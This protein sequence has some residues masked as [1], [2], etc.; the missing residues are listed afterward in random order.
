MSK[1]IIVSSIVLIA[2]G[3]VLIPSGMLVNTSINEMVE[4][5]VDEGL[6]GIEEEALP[7]VESMIAEL[8]I[9]RALRDIRKKGLSELETIVN[10]TFF[11]FLI[12]MT[13]HTEPVLGVV[14]LTMLFDKWIHWVL[15]IPV[16]YSSSLNGMG[17]PPIKGISEYYQ[18]NLWYG[19][20][21]FRIIE[22]T[23]TLPGLVGNN[24]MGT[25]VLEFLEL[26]EKATGNSTLEQEL[27]TGYNAT[28]NQ[29]VKLADYYNDYFVPIAIPMIV[30]NMSVVMPEYTGMDTKDITKMYFY[31]QWANCTVYEDGY[32]FSEIL[33]EIDD[34]LYGFEAGRLEPSN[35]SRFSINALWDD[36]NEKS[37]T[38]DSGINYWIAA[39]ENITIKEELR[40]EFSLE[41][42]QINMILNWLWN[43]SFKWDIV[44]VLITLPPPDGE[45][46]P[47]SEYAKVIFLEV[48]AN[49]TADG[50]SLYPYGFPLE[51]K[52]TTVYG[53]EVGYQNQHMSVI[54]SNISLESARYL[55]NVS[56]EFSLVNK[57]GLE[58]WFYAVENPDSATNFGLKMAN[59]LEDDEIAMILSWLPKFRNNVMPYLAQEEMNLIMDSTSLGNTIQLSMSLTGGVLIS[60]AVVGITRSII[61]KKK[62]RQ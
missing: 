13:L 28:W 53:F 19:A 23:E 30:A 62:L 21:K 59:Q 31:D 18:Q 57:K 44:P 33:D 27:V 43:E 39:A 55:W 54:P 17:Y 12:N 46:M 60:L 22:G 52:T 15:I 47:L 40:I 7:L 5:S 45:G 36:N 61:L 37:L 14:P 25:G 35:I 48:W 29:L 6:L 50:K 26:C 4:S 20:A 56:N 24:T 16:T 8:G 1:K 42:Y 9:P 38:N 51:L 11:M 10:A 58:E 34:P 32:D 3:G 49:G 41:E 2:I